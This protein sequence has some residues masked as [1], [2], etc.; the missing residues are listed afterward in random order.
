LLYVIDF[1]SLVFQVF[2]A[3]PEMTSP[4]G[5][6]TNAVF[7]FTRDILNILRQK[8]PTHLLC[9][10][11]P[12]GPGERDKLYSQYKAT[13]S[14]MPEELRPQFPLVG[15]TI[16]AFGIPVL[17]V[18]GWEADD[19][20]A[21]VAAAA[22]KR[23]MDVCIVT[24]DKDARQ[25]IRPRVRLYNVRKDQVYDATA[26]AA[27][28]FEPPC[29][30]C[31]NSLETT[32]VSENDPFDPRNAYAT[33]KVAQEYYAANWARVTG[34]SVAA[35]RY[36][37]VYGP[38]MPRDTPYAGVAAIFTSALRRGEAPK[39]FEDGRQ[40]RDFVNVRD[41]A[42]ATVTAC[43]N[44]EFSVRAFNIGSGTPR[45]VGD[46]ALALALALNGRQP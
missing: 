44:H 11:D 36:H 34:G 26:L 2:H 46:M 21:T 5:L 6:P 12:S 41:V 29:P 32:L 4:H 18:P 1:Y 17:E 23:D 25:L 38:G 37:N 9:A 42:S 33:S 35:L 43:E 39:V 10:T 45:T 16:A 19:V 22:G 13:R 31:G 24:N 20:I 8:T 3:I 40:R 14:P 27:G 28:K 7:G 15:R 30:I